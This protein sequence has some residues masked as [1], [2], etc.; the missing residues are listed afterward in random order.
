MDEQE[1][2]Q[3]LTITY[4]LLPVPFRLRTLI[5]IQ[6]PVV[7]NISIFLQICQGPVLGKSENITIDNK[8]DAPAGTS[9]LLLL[10]PAN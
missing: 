4:T 7:Y 3:G 6:F 1:K 8:K 10:I 9:S 5:P 2:K